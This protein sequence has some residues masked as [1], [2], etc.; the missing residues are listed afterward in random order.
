MKVS[1]YIGTTTLGASCLPHHVIHQLKWI[2]Y[3]GLSATAH[4]E[5]N[6]VGLPPAVLEKV[7][8][9]VQSHNHCKIIGYHL[10]QTIHLHFL[11]RRGMRT[12]FNEGI[13]P[14]HFINLVAT[15]QSV[16]LVAELF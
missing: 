9:L 1:A 2:E 13:W 12:K 11:C 3:L 14:G 7:F 15:V 4:L 8:R 16:E 6:L 5:P 10:N